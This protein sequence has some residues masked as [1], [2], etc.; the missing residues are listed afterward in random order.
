MRDPAKIPRDPAPGPSTS[1]KLQ[2]KFYSAFQDWSVV[3][4]LISLV[5]TVMVFVWEILFLN[6]PSGF[7]YYLLTGFIISFATNAF[8]IIAIRQRRPGFYLPYLVIRVSKFI[9]KTG[10]YSKKSL[11]NIIENILFREFYLSC[12]CSS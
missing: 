9:Y 12:T 8:V 6:F 3:F 4:A 7:K 10:K 5:Y 11:Q 2:H 1:T